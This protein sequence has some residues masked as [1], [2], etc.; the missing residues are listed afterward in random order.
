[1][2]GEDQ[3]EGG[4]TNRRGQG[5]NESR[6]TKK[7]GRKGTC[8]RESGE[9]ERVIHKVYA[10][11]IHMCKGGSKRLPEDKGERKERGGREREGGPVKI[12]Y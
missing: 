4:E 5:W 11:H 12:D 6:K 8:E 1:M 3:R 2:L 10:T 7:E 9:R